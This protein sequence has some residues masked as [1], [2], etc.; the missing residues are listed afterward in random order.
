MNT[1][2]ET[3]FGDSELAQRARAFY[4]THVA[5]TLT[6]AD[7]GKFLVI[8]TDTQFFA[9]DADDYKAAVQA[10]AQNPT[11]RNRFCVRVG[12]RAASNAYGS[13]KRSVAP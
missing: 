8:D 5:P 11:G 9:L 3:G 1:I 7:Y 12:H 13:A 6:D 10:V 4:E 2:N